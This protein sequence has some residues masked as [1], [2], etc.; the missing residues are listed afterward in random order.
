MH[1]VLDSTG[2]EELHLV[3]ASDAAKVGPE[4][5]LN[6]ECQKRPAFLSGEH[7][8]HET[9]HEGMHVKFRR[10]TNVGRLA[11]ASVVPRRRSAP[12]AERDLA[13]PQHPNPTINRGAI[14]FRPSGAF[15]YALLKTRGF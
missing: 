9:A 7:D 15:E 2:P 4:S 13:N 12:M 6:V 5:L 14:L 3:L 11:K 8:V 1:V 10:V